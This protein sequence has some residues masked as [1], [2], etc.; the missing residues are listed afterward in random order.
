MTRVERRDRT[1]LLLELERTAET[2]ARAA[3]LVVRENGCCSFFA[4]TLTAASGGPELTAA[5]PPAHVDVLDALAVRVS[6]AG[7]P[8]A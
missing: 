5:V 4:F 2:A 7:G 1:T 3:E 6:A 8:A